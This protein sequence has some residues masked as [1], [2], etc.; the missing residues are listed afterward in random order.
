MRCLF[1]VEHSIT[2]TLRGATQYKGVPNPLR[3]GYGEVMQGA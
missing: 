2:A 1:G 3:L